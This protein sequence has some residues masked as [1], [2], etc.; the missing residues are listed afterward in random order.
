M[1][2]NEKNRKNWL[3]YD[4]WRALLKYYYYKLVRQAGTPEYLARGMALGLFIG[5][6]IPMGGQIIVVLVLAVWLKAS[7]ILA[8]AGTM[9]TN[10][11]TVIII[12]PLQ[13][14][15]GSYLLFHPL[16]YSALQ[17]QFRGLTENFSYSALWALGLEIAVP[18]FVGGLFLGIIAGFAGYRITLSLVR[19]YRKHK[20]LRRQKKLKKLENLKN[21]QKK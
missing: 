12:Y 19:E 7:K 11:F 15:I 21:N 4:Y 16:K 14:L 20:E 5:F 17:E 13:C 3:H 10:W 8:I 1:A 9:V 18:F 2:E 6:L